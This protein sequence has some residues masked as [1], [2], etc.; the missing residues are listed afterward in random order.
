MKEKQKSYQK[1][2]GQFMTL[3]KNRHLQQGL[4][5]D[6]S[7]QLAAAAS[8]GPEEDL[9]AGAFQMQLLAVTQSCCPLPCSHRSAS[10]DNAAYTYTIQHYRLLY[11]CHHT[12]LWRL[13]IIAAQIAMERFAKEPILEMSI[14]KQ[15]LQHRLHYKMQLSRTEG[16]L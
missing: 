16:L 1:L 4:H 11:I 15:G 5:A 14:V 8:T 3:K 12:A 10:K 6:S 9:R 2:L 13:N 7:V